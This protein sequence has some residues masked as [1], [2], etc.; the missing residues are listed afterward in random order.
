[1]RADQAEEVARVLAAVGAA[2]D[3][4]DA[5]EALIRGAARLVPSTNGVIRTLGPDTGFREHQ[6]ART[7]LA[8][9]TMLATTSTM[10]PAS[11][12]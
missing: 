11:R 8:N 9:A 4:E 5:L 10:P 1:M 2:P 7:A 6:V 3:V 12:G